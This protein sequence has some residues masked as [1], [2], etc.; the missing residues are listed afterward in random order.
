MFI[1]CRPYKV[2]MKGF[3]ATPPKLAH[4]IVEFLFDNHPPSKGD[5]I[6]YP[7]VGEGPFI[8][9]VRDYCEQNGHPIPSGYGCDTHSGR[10]SRAKEKF[11]DLPIRF[12]QADFLDRTFDFGEF[13][14][15]VGNPPYVPITE[16][17]DQQKEQYRTDYETATGRFDLYLLF[18]ERALNLLADGGRLAFITPEKYEYTE[19]ARPLRRILSDYHLERLVHLEESSF[20]G[21]TT[22]PT[23]SVVQFCEGTKTTVVQRDGT[24]CDIQLPTD[25]T[26]WTENVRDIESNLEPTGVTLGDVTQRISAGVATGADS[27]FVFE[28]SE[29]PAQLE[30]W[31]KPTISGK[32]LE[33]QSSEEPVSHSSVFVCPYDDRGT[34]IPESDLS[35]FGEWLDSIHRS[36]LE[37]RSCYQNGKR[38]WYAWHENPPMSDIL[39]EKIL[40]RDITDSPEFW[41]D[42]TGSIVP[43]HSVYYLIPKEETHTEQLRTYLNS[44][45]VS[46]WLH[47]NCQKARN[48]YLRL[49]SRVLEDLPVP[50]QFCA[51]KQ[52]QLDTTTQ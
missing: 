24:V 19:T 13:E 1:Y 42:A 17:D 3:V 29:L 25:G 49:Q 44:P 22:Y 47:A 23:I 9:S 51:H 38:A 45:R 6:L 36:R 28:S 18:F 52:V 30:P 35:D 20:S 40:F 26:R 14:Y 5:R 48:D 33:Q 15:I 12:G 43:R 46:R 7:G 10:L 2:I 32:Q 11:A 34:I 21:Y 31:S 8:G 41:L 27:V 39:Q 16:I 50:E 4:Q 37:D